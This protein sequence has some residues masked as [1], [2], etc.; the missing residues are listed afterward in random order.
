MS[1]EMAL[2]AIHVTTLDK[3]VTMHRKI[4]RWVALAVVLIFPLGALPVWAHDE[5][6]PVVEEEMH[7]LPPGCRFHCVES[8]CTT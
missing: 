1:P 7:E 4:L 2:A 8:A 6:T 3:E 5:G